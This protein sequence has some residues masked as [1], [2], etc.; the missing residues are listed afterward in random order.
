MAKV[1][2]KKAFQLALIPMTA[3]VFLILQQYPT[4]DSILVDIPNFIFNLIKNAELTYFFA[5]SGSLGL[6]KYLETKTD[7]L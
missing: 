6:S 1:G 3:H 4:I 2:I 7:D 5:L